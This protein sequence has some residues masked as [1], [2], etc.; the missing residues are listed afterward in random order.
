MMDSVYSDWRP[1][2]HVCYTEN[3]AALLAASAWNSG[4]SVLILF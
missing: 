3:L 4:F 2:R 1:Q